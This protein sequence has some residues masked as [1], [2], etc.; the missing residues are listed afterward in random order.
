MTAKEVIYACPE[1]EANARGKRRI[2]EP[3]LTPQIKKPKE[4]R[5]TDNKGKDGGKLPCTDKLVTYTSLNT[6]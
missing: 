6:P 2:D 1:F 4:A 5:V 3:E